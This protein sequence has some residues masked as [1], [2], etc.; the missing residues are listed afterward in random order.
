MLENYGFCLLNNKYDS[1]S[2]KVNLDFNWMKNKD[3]TDASKK[4]K[5]SQIKKRIVLKPHKLNEELL[6]YIRSNLI[7]ERQK[8]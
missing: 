4:D 5:R 2:F 3:V 6:A 1:L 8:Q 7:Q